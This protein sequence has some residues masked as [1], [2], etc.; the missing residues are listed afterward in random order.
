MDYITAD[1]V[2]THGKVEFIIGTVWRTPGL[3][4]MS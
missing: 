4:E 1:Y 3:R 2:Q